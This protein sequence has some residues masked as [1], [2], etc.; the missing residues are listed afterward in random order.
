MSPKTSLSQLAVSSRWQNNF[1]AVIPAVRQHACICFRRLEHH[2]RQEAIAATVARAFVDYGNLVRRRRLVN[3][4]I[5]TLA[6]F[7]V[8]RVRAGRAVGAA[9]N[10]RDLLNRDPQRRQVR[11]LTPWES[12][13][14]RELVLEDRRV[15]PAD[16]AAFNLDFQAWLARWPPCATVPSLV[17]SPPGT[18]TAMSLLTLRSR[19][20]AF[21]SCAAGIGGPG[22]NYKASS[23]RR[24]QVLL[25]GSIPP[26]TCAQMLGSPD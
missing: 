22:N 5:S 4:Y 2:A 11:S 25:V 19:P 21:P 6:D 10:S 20:V 18:P 3:A 24:A 15:S 7:A 16:Q 17:P 23:R 1:L 8:R 26:F 9:Q 13:T 12:G 14:W